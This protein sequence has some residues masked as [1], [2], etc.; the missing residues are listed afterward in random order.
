M[1]RTDRPPSGELCPIAAELREFWKTKLLR[2]L[3]LNVLLQYTPI[4]PTKANEPSSEE[5]RPAKGNLSGEAKAPSALLLGA[6]VILSASSSASVGT[7]YPLGHGL[8]IP[9]TPCHRLSMVN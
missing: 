8:L 2:L 1:H 7:R 3:L 6:Q 4:K 9:L 5:R